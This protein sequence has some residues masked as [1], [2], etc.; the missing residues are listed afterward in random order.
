M[1]NKQCHR[2]A[3][4]SCLYNFRTL[5]DSQPQNTHSVATAAFWRTFLHD[6]KISPG[7]WAWGVHA[8]PLSLYLPSRTTLQCTVRSSWEGRYTPS[9]SSQ[10]LCRLLCVHNQDGLHCPP[11]I[12][13]ICITHSLNSGAAQSTYIT[14]VQQCLSPC[15]NWVPPAPLPEAS[16]YPFPSETG[17]GGGGGTTLAWGCG[18]WGSPNSD[19]CR[20]A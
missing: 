15:R 1:T 11:T 19:D 9:I 6:G 18:G 4:D 7:W 16:V 2:F 17:R 12:H 5:H 8:H 10:P 20:K 14:R 3:D 13:M